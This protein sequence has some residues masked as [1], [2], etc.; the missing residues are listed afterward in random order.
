[1]VSMS[2]IK[3]LGFDL[4]STLIN[5]DNQ[6]WNE[7]IKSTFP[8]LESLGYQGLFETYFKVWEEIF[9]GWRAYREDSHIELKSEVWWKEILNRLS[10]HFDEADISQIII[11]SHETFRT[12]ISL[13]P[14]VKELLSGLK[15]N[16]LL[17]CISNVSD[18]DLAREDM[19]I[20]GILNLFDCVVMSSDLGV[21]KPSPEIFEYALNTLKIKNTEMI[22]IGDTLYDDIQGAR[23]AGLLK[24]IHI[25]RNVSYYHSEYYIEA[26]ETI[27]DLHEICSLL[28]EIDI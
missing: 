28:K 11:K 27:Y 7:M 18:G 3:C 26:D 21:R 5:L 17:A 13:Y 25:R 4:Y 14:K 20:F 15:K 24:A 23:A 12:Q 1:M 6:N 19:E 9:W 10:I 8:I 2:R 22:F 16:Y